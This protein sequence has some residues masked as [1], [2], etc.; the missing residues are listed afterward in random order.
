MKKYFTTILVILIAIFVGIK[1]YR[2]E[3]LNNKSDFVYPTNNCV[4]FFTF[5]D[6]VH[7]FIPNSDLSLRQSGVFTFKRKSMEPYILYKSTDNQDITINNSN[8]DEVLAKINNRVSELKEL[9]FERDVSQDGSHQADLAQPY[10]AKLFGFK[11]D[12]DHYMLIVDN[13]ASGNADVIKVTTQCGRP[14]L[15]DDMILDKII[16]L[17][18]DANNQLIG[19]VSVVEGLYTVGLHA[20]YSGGGGVMEYWVKNGEDFRK[21]LTSQ[22]YPPCDL[23]QKEKVGKGLEC[24]YY[25]DKQSAEIQKVN[26]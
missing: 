18:K 13:I 21:I 8:L 26:Y 10:K 20:G 1:F 23:L 24:L 4:D 19:P 3:F 25:N 2:N 16:P 15:E 17:I 5:T 7:S 6:R 9:G 22:D 11:K 12:N 14:N